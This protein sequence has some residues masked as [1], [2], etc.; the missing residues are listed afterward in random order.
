[1]ETTGYCFLGLIADG[2]NPLA[3]TQHHVLFR[4]IRYMASSITVGYAFSPNTAWVKKARISPPR[5]FITQ[6]NLFRFA[7][8]KTERGTSYPFARTVSFGLSTTF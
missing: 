3:T 2:T 7:T 4:M 6:N 5:L 8:I 1:M